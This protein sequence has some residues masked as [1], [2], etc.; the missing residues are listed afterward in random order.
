MLNAS[1]PSKIKLEVQDT[2]DKVKSKLHLE[3]DKGRLKTK[4]LYKTQEMILA[5]QL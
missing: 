1:I 3:I 2:Q 4:K 5:L